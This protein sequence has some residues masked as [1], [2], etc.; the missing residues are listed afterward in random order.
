[1]YCQRGFRTGRRGDE[2]LELAAKA[3]LVTSCVTF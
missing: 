1:M 3:W 2:D